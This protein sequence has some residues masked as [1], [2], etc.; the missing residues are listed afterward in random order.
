[1]MLWQ[2]CRL[3]LTCTLLQTCALWITVRRT[4][5]ALTGFRGIQELN[6][7]KF[8]QLLHYFIINFHVFSMMAYLIFQCFINS[9]NQT[10]TSPRL[11]SLVPHPLNLAGALVALG[12]SSVAGPS[13]SHWRWR[14]GS[15]RPELSVP[16][17][18]RHRTTAPPPSVAR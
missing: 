4:W 3:V 2:I 10:S 7:P 15:A 6:G 14:P 11:R 9:M 12:F 5:Q 1:M 17:A 8:F 13:A 16:P 18:C